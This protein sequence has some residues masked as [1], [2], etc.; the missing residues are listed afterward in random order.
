[1]SIIIS[2]GVNEEFADIVR[3]WGEHMNRWMRGLISIERFEER[4]ENYL[5]LAEGFQNTLYGVGGSGI[6]SD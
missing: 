6:A 2:T 1:M 3:Q 5:Y 4:F